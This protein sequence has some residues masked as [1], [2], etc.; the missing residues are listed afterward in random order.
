LTEYGLLEQYNIPL[1]EGKELRAAF[2][3]AFPELAA[4]IEEQQSGKNFVQT[5]MGRKYWLNPYTEKSNRNA[6]NSPVQ[7][8]AGDALKIAG[9]KLIQKFNE[10]FDRLTQ[11]AYV[12]NLI[13]DEILVE[14]DED[15]K[16]EVIEIL[17]EVMISTA[18]EIHPGIPADVEIGWGYNWAE[19][20]G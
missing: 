1:E 20:H 4:W 3:N 8:S 10:R 19:A 2:L 5:I 12:I 9:Y 15:I 13:H 7:G 17:R 11:Y 16:D 14:C 18:E 6:I